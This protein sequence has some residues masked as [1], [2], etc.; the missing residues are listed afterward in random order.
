MSVSYLQ[1]IYIYIYIYMHTKKRKPH[2]KKKKNC[3]D[4]PKIKDTEMS[5]LD[6]HQTFGALKICK[7]TVI[8]RIM[9]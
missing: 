1:Y 6:K 9:K 2:G 8:A 5:W 7:I 4:I 3:M